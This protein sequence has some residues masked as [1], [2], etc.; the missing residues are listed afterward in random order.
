ML[1]FRCQILSPRMRPSSAAVLDV[2]TS[3][4]ALLLPGKAE[5]GLTLGLRFGRGR[6]KPPL[7]A[8]ARVVYCLEG[9]SGNSVLGC[10]FTA[11]L[12]EEQIRGILGLVR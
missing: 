8:S 9:A 3:G 4:V 11:P 10:E 6:R 7:E 12:T 2:S 1:V 5:P